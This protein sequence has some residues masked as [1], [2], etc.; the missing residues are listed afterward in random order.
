MWYNV[1]IRRLPG[2]EEKRKGKKKM[3]RTSYDEERVLPRL[4]LLEQRTQ[5][6]AEENAAYRLYEFDF[7]EPQF[8]AEIVYAGERAVAYLGTGAW[9]RDCFAILVAGRVTP[10]TLCDIVQDLRKTHTVLPVFEK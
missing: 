9:A 4:M 5:S 1:G 3:K 8:Y 2:G 6:V 7:A 10:C